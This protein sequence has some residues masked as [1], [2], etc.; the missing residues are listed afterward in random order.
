M[1]RTQD[2]VEMRKR[3][4]REEIWGLLVKEGLAAPPFPVRGRI[5]NFVGSDE[6]AKKLDLIIEY[7]QAN[8]VLI[9]PDY[10]LFH[11][12]VKSLLSGKS[13]L[14]ATPKLREGYLLLPHNNLGGLEKAASTISGS[15]R[16]GIRMN[17]PIRVD[18]VIEGCVAVDRSGN[19]LGKGG[20]YGDEEISVARR[21][22][23]SVKIAAVCSS[24][25]IVGTVPSTQADQSV[26]Y[27]VTEAG[28]ITTR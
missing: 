1:N 17:E 4:L 10:A 27:I 18:F 15:F 24:K 5:P 16:Y 26:D 14:L 21:L 23:P 2:S 3:R 25:Q 11:A 7:R 19:R 13:V 22:N 9:A 12:R 8:I 28:V 20:G 6:A